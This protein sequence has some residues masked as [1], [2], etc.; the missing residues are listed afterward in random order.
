MI[1]TEIV[2][3]CA[4]VCASTIITITI[5]VLANIFSHIND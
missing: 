3:I 5:I 4:T 1:D 2:I